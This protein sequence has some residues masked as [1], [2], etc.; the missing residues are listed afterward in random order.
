VT[1][2]GVN[3]V[4]VANDDS[5]STAEDTAVTFNVS[6]NDVDVDGNL[7]PSTTNTACATC[8]VPANG[9]LSNNGGGSFTY[10]PNTGFASTDGFV[11]EICDTGLLCDT[12]AVS[13]NV[14]SAVNAIDVRV[15][16]SS[17]D[18][19]ERASGSVVL[20]SSDIE[21]VF[22][23][24]GNQI[25]GL[26]FNN[27]AI[28]PNSTITQAHVQF[29][30]DEPKT[31]STSLTID[32][33]AV[34]HAATFTRSN[35]NVSS[36]PRTAASVSWSP[37]P[38]TIRGAAGADQQTPDI[39]S[40]I[41]EIV[42]RP[43]WSSGNSLVIIITGTGERTAE[44]Y[45]GEPAAAPLLHVGFTTGQQAP[46]VDAGPD[47][48]ITLPDS[49]TLDGTV[50][51]DGLPNPPGAVTT[52]WSQV[53][54][55]ATAV[56]A[57][58]SAVDTTATLPETGTYVLRLTANDGALVGSD[59]V[60]IEAI[61]AGGETIL[62]KRVSASSDDAEERV[63]GAT[64]LDSTDIELVFDAGGDQ[65][66]GMR[67][68]G[69]TIPQ[70]AT[71]LSAFVQFQEDEENTVAT[72]LTIQGEDVDDAATFVASSG[73]ITSRPRTTAAVPWAP[74]PWTIRHEVG[75][76]QQT[77]EIAAV[78]QEIVDRPGWV[79]GNSLVII[80]TGTGERTAESYDGDPF[81][82]PL[83]HVQYSMTP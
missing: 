57:D 48:T 54:G 67:F 43:A 10:T 14:M 51:D 77:P 39:T 55:P 83:L 35:F 25:V 72:S 34:D 20:T 18:A 70:G 22:D 45:N 80:V 60:T 27:L 62:E 19:E 74:P 11:Y 63:S 38:W 4:P 32:G 50:I 61:G 76:N 3:D 82:A 12:A 73:N 64:A 78:I 31:E 2:N 23:A 59:D 44:A 41:Q 49:A 40:I 1:V 5:T 42:A 81:G 75:P 46:T 47:Q 6:A 65:T 56:F 26:R 13:I 53:S 52:T 8:A 28:P 17:D 79:S 69:M 66:V 24:G 37:P 16:A 7:D 36:R 9:T 33:E 58:A 29:T 68:T 15:S 21:L 30:V 71:I